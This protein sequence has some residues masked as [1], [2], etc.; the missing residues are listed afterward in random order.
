MGSL[1]SHGQEDRVE[2]VNV[3]DC[4]FNGAES[5]TKIKTWPVFPPPK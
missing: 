5:A 3:W 1:G 2:N 4:H